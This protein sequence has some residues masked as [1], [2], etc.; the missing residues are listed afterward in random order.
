M[1]FYKAKRGKR[2][3]KPMIG[4]IYVHSSA[5]DTLTEVEYKLYENALSYIGDFT[6]DIVR[7]SVKTGDVS[8]T[9]SHDWD[10]A[11]EP[12]VGDSILVKS[13][14]SIKHTQGNNLIYH[15]KWMFVKDDYTGFDVEASKKRSE[16]WMNSEIV[17]RLKLDPNE[18]FNSKIGRRPYWDGKVCSV[19]G[20]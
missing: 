15:H 5:V 12:S 4:T 2:I 3:G 11:S 10:T 17:I 18:K 19:I 9:Q 13:D 16:Y 7:V 14:G 20:Y 1:N 8:F 6:F